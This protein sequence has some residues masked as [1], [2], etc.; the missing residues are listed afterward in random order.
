[1]LRPKAFRLG[2]KEWNRR[3][4]SGPH[5]ESLETRDLLAVAAL[6]DEFLVNG[7][8]TGSQYIGEIAFDATGDLFVTWRGSGP[9]GSG[10]YGTEYDSAGQQVQTNFPAQAPVIVGPG[11][12]V[13]AWSEMTEIGDPPDFIFNLWVR[14]Y[15]ANRQPLGPQFSIESYGST[16]PATATDDDGDFV[17]VW[18]GD[19][20]PLGGSGIFGR[21]F[22]S[23]GSALGEVFKVDTGNSPVQDPRVAMTPDGA[24]VVTWAANKNSTLDIYARRYST[25]GTALEATEFRVNSYTTGAQSSPAVAINADGSFVIAWQGIGQN[26]NETDIFVNAYDSTGTPEH[27]ADVAVN[28]YTTGGQSSPVV[29]INA[30]G[31]FAVAWQSFNQINS[32]DVIARRFVIGEEPTASAGSAYAIAEGDT[33]T[34]DASASSD[35]DG[36]IVS[37]SWDVNGDGVYGDAFGV[38]ST[39]TW[40]ELS[41]LGI[42][43][44]QQ[45]RNIKVK[46]TDSQ[47][48]ESI[49][50]AAVLTLNNAPPNAQVNA[51]NF[52]IR[53]QSRTFYFAATDPS[54]TDQAAP[55]TYMVDWENDGVVDETIVGNAAGVPLI[56]A[57]T[58]SGLHTIRVTATDKDGGVS[59]PTLFQVTVVAWSLLADPNDSSKTDLHW[60][61]TTGVDAYAFV[62]GLVLK[63]AENNQFYPNPQLT[64]LPSF[65][66]KIY[67]YGQGGND[68]VFADIVNVPLVVFGG[69][70]DDVLVGG[71]AGDSLDGGDGKDI[72][73]GG[74]LGT[75]GDDLLVGGA[76]DDILI[77]HW[78]ADTLHGGS[79]SDLVMAGALFFADLPSAIYSIQAE[80]L[81]GRPLATRVENL[82]GVGIGPR[83]NST[84]FLEPGVTA[85]DD[86]AVDDVLGEAGEDW[87]VYDFAADLAADFEPGVDVVSDLS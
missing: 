55:F 44:G 38:M 86:N 77:G 40:S 49:S 43:D 29:A 11:G 67:V 35:I 1:M 28:T 30:N 53:G 78:G 4:N 84:Y 83:F 73:F 64:F 62:P 60:G 39:L 15:D 2:Q 7:Y 80:W 37:Y 61:G 31:D 14:Q 75:D 19:I 21:R 8:T 69:D 87:L 71:R 34:L 9:N 25:T 72:L 47:G 85:L 6:G 46:V 33:L 22:D 54:P 42:T 18:V 79:G 32:Y 36:V 45:T 56:H 12:Y 16:T 23:S 70:G 81:S 17:V 5:F 57:F 13:S 58:H 66:G 59:G 52:M 41:S 24:F 74:T 50:P 68:L 63:Q 3:G 10:I 51:W 82:T 76:G 65:N 27:A 20:P 26:F 48:I